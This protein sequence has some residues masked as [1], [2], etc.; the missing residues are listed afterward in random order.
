MKFPRAIL[1][2]ASVVGAF[3]IA[4]LI[5]E[6]AVRLA[7]PAYDPS[8][9]LRFE[10]SGDG[11][12]TLGPRNTVHRLVKNSGDYD[13][14]VR[15][16]RYGLRDSR[17][18]AEATEDDVFVVGDSFGFGWGVEAED[19]FSERLEK[20]IGNRVFNIAMTSDF[21]GYARL[22]R[23]AAKNGAAVRKVIV[24]VNM[25]D[26]L[27]PYDDEAAA[28]TDPNTVEAPTPPTGI[29]IR[30]VQLKTFL[31]AHSALY[32]L[33]TSLIHRVDPLKRL[34][35]KLGLIVTIE[36]VNRSVV[37]PR[38]IEISAR[39]LADVV[40]PYEATI[41]I[42]PTRGLWVGNNRDEDDRIHRLV[43]ERFRTIGLDV[44]D[45]R[46]AFEEGGAPMRYHFASDGHWNPAG[47]AR[48][49]E[50]LAEHLKARGKAR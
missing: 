34:G 33:A 11:G 10:T 31:L 20:L 46:Q 28:E 23:Y 12:L 17:D 44:V 43:V 41:L 13:V 7:L 42:I 22:L 40:R 25:I 21:D 14:T 2:A 45:P 36:T 16:N 19:R 18:L 38:V 50:L 48:V 35:I 3:A 37:T 26:D 6:F 1:T 8:G 15:F 24:A 27:L 30:L 32:F 9:H 49:A 4:V 5:Q 29:G 47:H 39:R